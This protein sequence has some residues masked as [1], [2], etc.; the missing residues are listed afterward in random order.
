MCCTNAPVVTSLFTDDHEACYPS[1]KSAL[2][3]KLKVEM[4]CRGINPDA[5]VIAGVAMLHSAI[6]WPK[7][8]SVSD[9]TEGIDQYIMSHLKSCC[10]YLTFDRYSEYSIKSDTH[11]KRVGAF[12][13]KHFLSLA[14]ILSA[15][16]IYLLVIHN[17]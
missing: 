17:D 8:G 6:Y 7:D 14:A 10:V 11:R 1:N 9:L 3:N 16:D 13:K 12:P 4:S 5:V 15:K 2:K